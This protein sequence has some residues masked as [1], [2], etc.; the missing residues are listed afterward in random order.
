MDNSYLDG[1]LLFW[2]YHPLSRLSLNVGNSVSPSTVAL[3]LQG[4]HLFNGWGSGETLT[5]PCKGYR[6]G[7]RWF[8]QLSWRIFPNQGMNLKRDPFILSFQGF[9]GSQER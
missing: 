2:T 4:K 1:E 7:S 3:S 5:L 6:K 9:Q 8:Y